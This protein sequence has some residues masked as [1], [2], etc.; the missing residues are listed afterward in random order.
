MYQSQTRA[1]IIFKDIFCAQII[2]IFLGHPV[3]VQGE[4]ELFIS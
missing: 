4:Q 2:N 1:Y 3:Y